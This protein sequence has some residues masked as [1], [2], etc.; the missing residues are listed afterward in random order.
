MLLFVLFLFFLHF[1]FFFFNIDVSLDVFF[2]NIENIGG[3]EHRCLCTSSVFK[4]FGFG[5]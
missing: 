2:E 3:H 5:C 1:L 4:C